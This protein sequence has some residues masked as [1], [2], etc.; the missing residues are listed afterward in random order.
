MHQAAVSIA[1]SYGPATTECSLPYIFFSSFLVS[2]LFYD[3]STDPFRIRVDGA[4]PARISL[5][6]SLLYRW[7]STSKAA[8]KENRKSADREEEKKRE[9][10]LGA[11]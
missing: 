8:R 9:P 2:T 4:S 11:R 7:G 1:G 5:L 3:D 10:L 6:G